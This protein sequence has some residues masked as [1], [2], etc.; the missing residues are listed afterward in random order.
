[1]DPR[2][3]HHRHRVPLADPGAPIAEHLAEKGIDRRSLL[4]W[5][6]AMAVVL[7]LPAVPYA[8]RIVEAATTKPRLPVLWLNG[9]ECT[10]DMESVLRSTQN[11]PSDLLLNQIS[12]DYSELL[13][14]TAG[15]GA[16]EAREAT[17]SAY[18]GKYVVIV[19][20]SIPLAQGGVFCTVGGQSFASLVKASAADSLGVIAAGTC[21]S[22]GGLPAARG[23]VTGA[24]SVSTH[25]AS[26]GK[27]VI[28]LPGCPVNAETLVATLVSYVALGT[29]PATDGTGRPL[30]AYQ[31][32]IHSRCE[33]RGFY[34]S[35]QFVRAWGD[36][37]EQKG[38]CLR[39]MG[40]QGPSTR[41]DC[42][43]T[44]WNG[45]TSWPVASGGPCVGCANDG[46]WDKIDSG[47]G[48]G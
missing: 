9:Q 17:I 26:S 27:K 32:T 48:H 25:L 19:D 42:P 18:G 15:S 1:M 4:K 24:T 37:G 6:A 20:G 12:L 38:W 10:G 40:C 39:L 23:G 46:F 47:G 16:E 30:F 33:R 35:G 22:Y 28:L 8:T 13:M 34:E 11:S 43:T 7:G 29:W 31:R 2:R 14:A 45:G 41:S 36:A 21:A 44:K 3:G 5:S